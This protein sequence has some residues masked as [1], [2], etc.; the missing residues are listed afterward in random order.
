M[1]TKIKN[2]LKQF[3]WACLPPSIKYKDIW[4]AEAYRMIDS[5]EI[6]DM[7]KSGKINVYDYEIMFMDESDPLTAAWIDVEGQDY[8]WIWSNTPDIRARLNENVISYLSGKETCYRK[9]D[10]SIITITDMG[11][12]QFC[13]QAYMKV[14]FV[15]NQ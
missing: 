4:K 1:L 11:T 7:I 10:H 12:E 6:I 13:G 14:L 3:W 2:L 5:N 15:I 9:L 8:G